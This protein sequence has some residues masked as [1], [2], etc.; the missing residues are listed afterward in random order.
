MSYIYIYTIQPTI[1]NKCLHH[2]T[3]SHAQNTTLPDPDAKGAPNARGVHR[4]G[5]FEAAMVAMV[6][7][8]R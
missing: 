1:Y 2:F 8:I 7:L 3:A 4:L 6:I 5:G